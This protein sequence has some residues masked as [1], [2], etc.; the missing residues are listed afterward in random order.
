MK[1]MFVALALFFIIVCLQSIQGQVLSKPDP[2]AQIARS[3]GIIVVVSTMKGSFYLNEIFLTKLNFGDTIRIIN[4]NPGA[5]YVKVIGE[6][7][8]VLN[9]LSLSRRDA[10]EIEAGNDTLLII[11]SPESYE[12][13][14]KT[15]KGRY[16]Y[17]IRDQSFFNITETSLYS[18]YLEASGNWWLGAFTTISGFQFV[19][20]FCAGLGISYYNADLSLYYY[21]DLENISFLPLFLDLRTHLSNRRIAPFLKF[22]IGYNILLSPKSKYQ[23][24]SGNAYINTSSYKLENGGIYLSPGMGLRIAVNKLIQIIL[25]AE[26][27]YGTCKY[28]YTHDAHYAGQPSNPYTTIYTDNIKVFRLNL[29]IGF[30]K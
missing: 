4:I 14:A 22:D 24:H 17:F 9:H 28:S 18:G 5:Y 12:D 21:A 1:K 25:T 8:T 15:V 26:F 20:G 27:E 23:N 29:G 19:P 7:S 3:K 2:S 10:Y 6:N 16:V 13:I 30:Q 11:K